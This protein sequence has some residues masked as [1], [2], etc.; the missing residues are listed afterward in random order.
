[1]G[2][3]CLLIN[4]EVKNGLL[5]LP[6]CSETLTMCNTVLSMPN[7]AQIHVSKACQQILKF[8]TL[9]TGNKGP[10]DGVLKLEAN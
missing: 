5:G 10:G 6:P 9:H 3:S 2:T 8:L 7:Q 4:T 1:M